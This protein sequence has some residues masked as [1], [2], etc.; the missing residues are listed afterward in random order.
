MKILFFHI[1]GVFYFSF[2]VRSFAF[3]WENISFPRN[4]L[5]FHGI[6]QFLLG[7]FTIFLKFSYFFWNLLKFSRGSF[8]NFP[9]KLNICCRNA[10]SRRTLLNFLLSLR[11]T[12]SPSPLVCTPPQRHEHLHSRHSRPSP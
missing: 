7:L 2:F 12:S 8:H 3:L 11:P 5:H 9:R 6:L 1:Y 10:S 4:F